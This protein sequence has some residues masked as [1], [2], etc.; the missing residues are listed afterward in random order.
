[1]AYTLQ[2]TQS[3]PSLSCPSTGSS[4]VTLQKTSSDTVLRGIIRAGPQ[5]KLERLFGYRSGL[6]LAAE[7]LG[8][9][10]LGRRQVYEM[11]YPGNVYVFKEKSG[12]ESSD[13]GF[14]SGG[15]ASTFKANVE[16][17][18]GLGQDHHHLFKVH[19]PNTSLKNLASNIN[20]LT[21]FTKPEQALITL[22]QLMLILIGPQ[23]WKKSSS[24]NKY[25]QGQLNLTL[26][27]TNKSKEWYDEQISKAKETRKQFELVLATQSL[28]SLWAIAAEK[29]AGCLRW[30]LTTAPPS[31]LTVIEAEK[32]QE[33][34]SQQMQEMLKSTMERKKTRRFRR[35]SLAFASAGQSQFSSMT[36]A[37]ASDACLQAH[38]EYDAKL[39]DCIQQSPFPQFKE[40]LSN[41]FV[42]KPDDKDNFKPMA[43]ALESTIKNTLRFRAGVYR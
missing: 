35:K 36:A 28:I 23:A 30:C 2:R 13:S 5:K 26:E 43:R 40:A 41:M 19:T 22:E 12:G 17:G 14:Q 1:M 7:Y 27:N 11:S 32:L 10:P 39:D 37:H 33:Q 25:F 29:A 6:N 38:K 4:S 34:F 24:I 20:Q 42:A 16:Y 8:Q 9:R 18:E 31:A 21:S 15:Q 3:L